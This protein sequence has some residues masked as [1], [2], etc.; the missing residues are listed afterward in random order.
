MR[1]SLRLLARF[2]MSNPSTTPKASAERAS[3]LLQ[4]L[5]DVRARVSAAAG[6][7]QS[8]AT[9]VAV[10]K[11]KPASDILACYEHGQRD[12]GENYVQELVEKAEQVRPRILLGLHPG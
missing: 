7:R 9:L 11:I 5:T 1:S 3:E 12:F 2:T 8:E 10:S 4:C 6:S